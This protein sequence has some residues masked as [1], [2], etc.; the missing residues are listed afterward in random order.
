MVRCTITDPLNAHA[1][2]RLPISE[3]LAFE[4]VCI[5]FSGVGRVSRLSR[6]AI[7]S[8]LN[9]ERQDFRIPALQ[10]ARQRYTEPMSTSEQVAA[11]GPEEEDRLYAAAHLSR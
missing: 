3:D 10:D 1:R 7:G 2:Q 9:A 6:Y 4:T 8:R 11:M 5:A